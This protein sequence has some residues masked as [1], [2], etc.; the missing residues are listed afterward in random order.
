MLYISKMDGY[1]KILTDKEVV[2]ILNLQE[3]NK[4]LEKLLNCFISFK[5]HLM[6]LKN[7][8]SQIFLIIVYV[9]IMLRFYPELQ[10]INT[11]PM[12]KNKQVT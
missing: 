12:I 10:L 2:N 7:I 11:K 6:R 9:A 1:L 8:Y 5:R 4:I 3:K